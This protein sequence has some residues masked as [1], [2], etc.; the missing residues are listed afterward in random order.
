MA[1]RLGINGSIVV[2]ARGTGNKIYG[3]SYGSWAQIGTGQATFTGDLSAFVAAST[4]GI[5]FMDL[6]TA[7]SG[8]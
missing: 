7:S 6:A 3:G 5:V 1:R 8:P 4:N 2:V